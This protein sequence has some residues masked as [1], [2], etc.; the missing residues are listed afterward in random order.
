MALETSSVVAE[1][2]KSL[3]RTPRPASG[4]QPQSMSLS[5]FLSFYPM[6]LCST[7][8]CMY[9]QVSSKLLT[10]DLATAVTSDTP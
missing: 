7:T 3:H 9:L 4:F 6:S 10:S 1:S 8:L 2:N 5:L